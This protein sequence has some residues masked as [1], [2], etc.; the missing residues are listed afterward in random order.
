MTWALSVVSAGIFV[1]NFVALWHLI[2]WWTRWRISHGKIRFLTS[3]S[4]GF[5]TVATNFGDV[6]S[7]WRVLDNESDSGDMIGVRGWKETF[8]SQIKCQLNLVTRK[9]SHMWIFENWPATDAKSIPPMWSGIAAMNC[10]RGGWCGPMI[11]MAIFPTDNVVGVN[12]F[13]NWIF[14]I[15]LI[16]RF[17]LCV[18]YAHMWNMCNV[19][20]TVRWAANVIKSSQL[21]FGVR[22]NCVWCL[23]IEGLWRHLYYLWSKNKKENPKTPN[24]YVYKKLKGTN[25]TSEEMF[26]KIE[27]QNLFVSKQI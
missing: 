10:M 22:T 7:I 6:Q 20:F 8:K 13:W 9:R 1:R 17:V 16:I 27:K 4:I 15:F 23:S 19:H 18:R 14:K 5:N 25:W 11:P 24:L 3:Y 26:F 2:I 21:F 12:V